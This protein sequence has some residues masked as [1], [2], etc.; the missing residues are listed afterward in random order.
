MTIK[1][2]EI[3]VLNYDEDGQDLILTK[4]EKHSLEI[5]INKFGVPPRS[6]ML[7]IDDCQWIVVFAQVELGNNPMIILNMTNDENYDKFY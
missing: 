7:G 1:G 3:K 6:T 4:E 2:F 5:F